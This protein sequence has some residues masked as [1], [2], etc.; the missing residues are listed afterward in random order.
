MGC[1]DGYLPF[2]ARRVPPWKVYANDID[3]G[4]IERLGSGRTGRA[5]NFGPGKGIRGDDRVKFV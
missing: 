5:C 2:L 1:G 3:E 4:A